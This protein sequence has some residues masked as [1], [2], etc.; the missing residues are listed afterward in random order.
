M[1]LMLA[2][3]QFFAY[4]TQNLTFAYC[5]ELLVR[6][7]RDRAF[8]TMLRQDIA[9][10]DKEE[11]TTGALTTFLS[12]ETTHIAG[13]SGVTLGTILSVSTTLVVAIVVGLAVGWKLALVC[14]ACVPLLLAAGFWRF[15]I[16]SQFQQRAKKAYETSGGFACEA[17]AAIRTVASLTREKDVWNIYHEQL[18]AQAKTSLKSVI[19]TSS[20]YALAQSLLSLIHI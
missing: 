3:V 1:Y 13:M 11:N 8:R 20:L 17:T 15:H 7:V 18:D 12:T 9:F 19:R 10:F 5:S 14:T 16:I 4:V 2:I 6:R